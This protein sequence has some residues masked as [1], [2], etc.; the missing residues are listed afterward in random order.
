MEQ[1]TFTERAGV[2]YAVIGKGKRVHYSPSNDDG[3]CGRGITSYLDAEEAVA[4]FSKGFELCAPCHRAAEKRAAAKP[5]VDE[6]LDALADSVAE[7]LTEADALLADLREV[8]ADLDEHEA[9]VATFGAQVDALVEQLAQETAA[10]LAAEQRVVEGVIVEHAGVAEGSTPSNATHPNV[11]AARGA[12]DNLAF[13]RMTDH[14]DTSNPTEDEQNVRGY[15]VEPR[16]GRRVAVYWLEGGRIIRRDQMPHGPA[17]DCLADRLSKRGWNVEPMLRSSQCVFAHRPADGTERPEPQPAPT[18][19]ENTRAANVV[20]A[21]VDFGEPRCVH[22]VFPLDGVSGEPIKACAR[23]ESIQEA[24]VFSD[25]GCVEAYDCAV[26]AANRAADMNAEEG[27][28][29][30]DPLYM[31]DLLCVE[32][33]DSEQQVDTCEECNATPDEDRCP[34]CSGKGCHWCHWTGEE[35]TEQTEQTAPIELEVV[36]DDEA[37]AAGTWREGWIAS[38]PAPADVVL[39]DL[40]DIAEQGALFG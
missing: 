23:K 10:P 17:L 38:Q 31:W 13:A 1:Q 18:L 2:R 11:V 5:T 6:Q 27:A 21:G 39:F 22:N 30:S 33:R 32:H 37:E 26:Q 9:A 16:G 8:G 12:L 24:G 4:L 35:Q 36:H 34:E 25:E 20:L 19:E 40:G 7:S 28:P 15:L 29:A 14:H 3:L